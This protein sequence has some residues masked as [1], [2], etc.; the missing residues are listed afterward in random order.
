MR[1]TLSSFSTVF[2]GLAAAILCAVPGHAG[3]NQLWTAIVIDGPVAPDSRLLA[4]FDG[5]ARFRDD[6]S[7]L[8]VSIIRPGIGYR[9][10]PG[11]D[12]WAGYARVTTQLDG[13]DIKENRAW[14]QASFSAG[15]LFGGSLSG[16]SRLEQRF[17]STGD[18]VGHRFRQFFRWSRPLN[19]DFSLVLWDELFLAL[20]TTDWGQRDGFDQNRLFVGGA[21][22]IAESIRLD[23]GYLH[24]RLGRSGGKRTNHNLSL[25]LFFRL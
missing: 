4:W 17:R 3:D 21:W 14:Q 16:R 11:L 22:H 12:L 10:A 9:A 7:E 8:G 18:D 5:H 24:N 1:R 13:P 19:S 6:A 15:R 2:A 20:N 23:A 25:S